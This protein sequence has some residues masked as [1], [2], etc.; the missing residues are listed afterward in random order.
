M[1]VWDFVNK[2]TQPQHNKLILCISYDVVEGTY[3]CKHL[4]SIAFEVVL[5]RFFLVT[6]LTII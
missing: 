4:Q 3:N 2:H 1:H 5:F 6:K